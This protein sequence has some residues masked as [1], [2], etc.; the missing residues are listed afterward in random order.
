MWLFYLINY[1]KAFLVHMPD[2][3]ST[4]NIGEKARMNYKRMGREQQKTDIHE[5]RY[6]DM[7][8]NSQR[9]TVGTVW[10]LDTA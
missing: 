7:D 8:K 4:T 2:N 9:Q 6:R 10:W 5:R 1:I 3:V